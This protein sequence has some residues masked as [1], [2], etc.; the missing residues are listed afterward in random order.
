MCHV[1]FA[2]VRFQREVHVDEW[3]VRRRCD[4]DKSRGRPST[5]EKQLSTVHAHREGQVATPGGRCNPVSPTVHSSG[6][7]SRTRRSNTRWKYFQGV[8]ISQEHAQLVVQTEHQ[9]FGL[10]ITLST[11]VVAGWDCRPVQV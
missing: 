10:K 4:T 7:I 1:Q 11:L 8:V 2:G 9:V 5:C 6:S 3:F